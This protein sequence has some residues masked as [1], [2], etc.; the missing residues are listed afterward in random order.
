MSGE[1]IEMNT[2]EFARWVDK[3]G[4]PKCGSQHVRKTQG[5]EQTPGRVVCLSCFWEIKLTP[6]E[7]AALKSS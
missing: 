2:A 5:N 4:C 1:K 3:G 7:E 6:A